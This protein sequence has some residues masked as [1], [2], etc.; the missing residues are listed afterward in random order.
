ML[1]GPTGTG[2]SVSAYS[3]LISGMPDTYQYIPMTL[4]SQSN[5]NQTQ[6][7]IDAKL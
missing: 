6:D 7:T 3:L 5:A 1:P 2:K 4:S